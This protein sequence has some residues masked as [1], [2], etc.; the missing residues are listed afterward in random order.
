MCSPTVPPTEHVHTEWAPRG[1]RHRPAHARLEGESRRSWLGAWTWVVLCALGCAEATQTSVHDSAVSPPI[2]AARPEPPGDDAD[3]ASPTR[4]VASSSERPESVRVV[5][6]TGVAPFDSAVDSAGRLLLL[7][8]E[9]RVQ[10]LGSSGQVEHAFDVKLTPLR[11]AA[12]TSDGWVAIG[13][14]RE[15]IDGNETGA[16]VLVRFDG[17]IGSVWRAP[18]VLVSVASHGSTIVASDATG[19]TYSVH[20]NGSFVRLDPPAPVRGA[21]TRAVFWGDELAFCREGLRRPG[22]DPRGVCVTVD[23]QRIDEVWRAPP[24]ACGGYLVANV[25]A[26]G[27]TTSSWSRVIWSGEGAQKVAEQRLSQNPPE[28]GCFRTWLVDT[29]LPGGLLELPSAAVVRSPLCEAGSDKIVVG[30]DVIWCLQLAR[31]P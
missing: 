19:G 24:V 5:R 6:V 16:A 2:S 17:S 20:A 9:G 4:S 25:Q 22:Q 18:G 3:P 29:E 7:S 28:P 1:R 27:M 11:M 21:P 13:S 31:A 8:P 14:L 23:G 15:D 30:A 10:I 12:P 26:N